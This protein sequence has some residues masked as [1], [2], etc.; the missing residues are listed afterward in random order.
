MWTRFSL[1]KQ[2]PCY[3]AISS[4]LGNLR[5]VPE[6]CFWFHCNCNWPRLKEG[7]V[8]QIYCRLFFEITHTVLK[9]FSV[10]SNTVQVVVI[11][12][13]NWVLHVLANI[14]WADGLCA[15]QFAC[16]TSMPVWPVIINVFLVFKFLHFNLKWIKNDLY[17]WMIDI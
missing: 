5:M 11:T 8:C 1:S 4:W 7:T 9:I 12:R 10:L 16:L 6:R 15:C 13:K 2:K 14:F 3:K 17:T